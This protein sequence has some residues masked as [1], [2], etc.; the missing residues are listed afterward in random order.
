MK[1]LWTTRALTQDEI[2]QVHAQGAELAELFPDDFNA[3]FLKT[4]LALGKFC[5]EMGV[6]GPPQS[7]DVDFPE[8]VRLGR[9]YCEAYLAAASL[10]PTPPSRSPCSSARRTSTT[11]GSSRVCRCTMRWGSSGCSELRSSARLCGHTKGK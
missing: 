4:K 1:E 5:R 3:I 7:L 9:E 10:A 11:T 6:L 2:F 8:S